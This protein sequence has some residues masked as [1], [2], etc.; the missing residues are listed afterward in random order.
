[1]R[2]KAIQ[3]KILLTGVIGLLAQFSG[4]AYAAP[5]FVPPSPPIVGYVAQP[6]LSH[7]DLTT[8][9]ES[10]FRGEYERTNWSGNLSCYAVSSAGNVNTSV[11]C[12]TSG[13]GASL[14]VGAQS[15]VDLQG[16]A[17][18]SRNIATLGLTGVPQAFALAADPTDLIDA[19]HVNYIRGDRSNEAPAGLLL[20]PRLSVLGDTIH[21]RPFYITD[22]GF[23]FEV[24]RLT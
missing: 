20:R 10:V 17:S 3:T 16:F 5:L 2:K 19:S 4:M 22:R 1:M 11:P 15:Q 18:G 24:Q 12:W 9:N 7:Y 6:E 23:Q 8:G 13:T 14:K 21:S